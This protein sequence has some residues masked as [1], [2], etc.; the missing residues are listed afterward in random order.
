MRTD[1]TRIAPEAQAWAAQYI[2]E[3]FGKEYIPEKP[4]KYKVKANAQE[5]HEAIRPTYMEYPPEKIKKY[6]QKDLY[7]LYELIWKRFIASQMA[8]AQLEQTTF[9]IV[10]SS[11]K[12]I[13]RTTGT[14]IKF[15][16]F[17]A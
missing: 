2:L 7:A 1:S 10:D 12:A 9:E 16:G 15:N 4:H 14:V 13:F 6:L 8:A 3:T 17:L 11:E 5:A